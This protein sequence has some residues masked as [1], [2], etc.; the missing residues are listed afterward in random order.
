MEAAAESSIFFE[1]KKTMAG[2][3]DDGYAMQD[4]YLTKV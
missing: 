4:D 3:S 1:K 2:K